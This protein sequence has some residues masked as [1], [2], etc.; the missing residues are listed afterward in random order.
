MRYDLE[1]FMAP[2][3]ALATSSEDFACIKTPEKF[4]VKISGA[5]YSLALLQCFIMLFKQA[6]LSLSRTGCCAF[7]LIYV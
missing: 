4:R 3:T 5:L 2:C 7:R 6:V 1:L